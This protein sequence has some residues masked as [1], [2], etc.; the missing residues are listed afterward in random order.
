VRGPLDG[1]SSLEWLNPPAA[2]IRLHQGGGGYG[3][4]YDGVV[5]VEA[6][7]T[8][9]GIAVLKGQVGC[10]RASAARAIRDVL[11]AAGYVGWQMER[12]NGKVDRVR[13]FRKKR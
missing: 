8:E 10:P 4:P 1:R 5:T 2:L 13:L 12:A 3:S 9:P 11:Y 6:H 7:A